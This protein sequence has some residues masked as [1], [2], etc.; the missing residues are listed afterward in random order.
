MPAEPTRNDTMPLPPDA[1]VG[2][3][4]IGALCGEFLMPLDLLPGASLLGPL[5]YV[6]LALVGSGLALEV[7]AA[8][9]LSRA[10]AS[11]RPNGSATALVTTGVF[12]WSRNPFYLGILLLVAGAMLGFSLDWGVIFLALLWLALDRLVVPV[13]ERRLERAFGQAYFTYAAATRRWL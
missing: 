6:G 4:A 1:Y 8:R 13:E 2:M 3:A 7:A 10:G 11:T 5:T 12:R 9:A